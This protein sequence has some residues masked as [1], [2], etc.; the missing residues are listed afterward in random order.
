MLVYS[1]LFFLVG[2]IVSL[3]V[4]ILA[5]NIGNVILYKVSFGMLLFQFPVVCFLLYQ[6]INDINNYKPKQELN[7]L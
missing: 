5:S 2:L 6:L 4:S 7:L 1:T 3:S